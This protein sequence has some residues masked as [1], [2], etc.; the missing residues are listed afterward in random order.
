MPKVMLWPDLYREH[1]HWLPAVNLA[2]SLRSAGHDVEFM[3]IADCEVIVQ[4]YGATFYPIFQQLY[5]TG[6]TVNDQLEPEGQRWK[7]HHLLPLARGELSSLFEGA[8]PPA[9]L[10]AGYF[11]ALEA[12]ILHHKHGVPLV[13]LTTYL[14]HPQEDPASIARSKLVYMPEQL[15]QKIIDTATDSTGMTLEE[16][17]QPLQEV[18]E[19]IPCPRDFDF[20]DDDWVHRDLTH[21]VEPMIARDPLSENP[22]DVPNDIDNPIPSEGKKIIFATAG[23][24]VADYEDKAKLFFQALIDM[25]KTQG[26]EN[27]H[28]VLSVG[29]RL[30]QHFRIK[31]GIDENT[32]SNDLPS[33]VSLAAWV[34]QLDIL[35]TAE[36]VFM[37]GGL[38]TIKE[39]IAEGVPIVIFPH[40]KDQMENALRIVRAGLGVLPDFDIVTPEGLRKVLTQTTTNK[41]LRNKVEG[42]QQLFLAEDAKEPP[43]SM[44]ILGPLLTTG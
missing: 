34:S 37:H 19:L 43:P 32:G 12:L 14:R 31:Y 10:I 27:H 35:K 8:D 39:S 24:Q 23:S 6:H 4:P 44:E 21:Y 30:L 42:M 13:V 11:V 16:F 36:V 17:L 38:A 33:N 3:G 26:M 15:Q 20:F 7:P 2:G 5:P 28:L 1:G 9:L 18:H 41:W 25:M 22:P 40:G 29:D